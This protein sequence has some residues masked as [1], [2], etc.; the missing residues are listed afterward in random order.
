MKKVLCLLLAVVMMLSVNVTIFADEA[1]YV[2]LDGNYIEFDV[3]PQIINGRT[4]V[5][6][7]AIF[8]KMGAVVEWD[9]NTSSAICTKDGTVVKMT[10][11]SMYMYINGLVKKMD[12]APVVI[13]GRTLAP[14]RFVAEAF[15]ADVQWKQETNTVVITSENIYAYADFPDIPDLGKCYNIKLTVEEIQESGKVYIYDNVNIINEELGNN[16]YKNSLKN[17]GNYTEEIIEES[18]TQKVVAYTK[19]GEQIRKFYVASGYYDGK[20]YFSVLIPTTTLYALD[21]R[22]I[23][24]YD[25]EVPAYKNVGWYET[26]AE[27]QQ[28]MYAADGRTITVYKAEVPAYKN[29]GW[30]ETRA[31]ASAANKTT[32]NTTVSN[33]SSVSSSS[34]NSYNPTADGNYYRT[35]TGKKYHLDPNCGGKNSYKTSDISGLDPC[36]KC[37]K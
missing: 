33:N 10:V 1:I 32:S 8:E 3:M 12:I 6:I 15:G 19:Q 17:L 18:G 34:S 4:M 29:V 11:D 27:T 13:N 22:T 16:A 9:A 24:V 30:Y 36:A 26:L 37:A 2:T 21:G 35:P 23:T 25:T 7:R 20:R 5:P 31:A 28:T 14:A